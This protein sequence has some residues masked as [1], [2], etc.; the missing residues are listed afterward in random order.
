MAGE[1]NEESKE[2]VPVTFQNKLPVHESIGRN[3]V[4][5]WSKTKKIL[6]QEVKEKTTIER[7]DMIRHDLDQSE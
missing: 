3:K 5:S 4:V 1:S 6:T 7:S 2:N